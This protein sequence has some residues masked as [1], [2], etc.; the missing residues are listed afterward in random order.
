MRVNRR[1]VQLLLA[2]TMVLELAA[3]APAMAQPAEPYDPWEPFNRK[4]FAVNQV[5]DRHIFAPLAHAFGALPPVIRKPLTNFASNIGEPVVFLNDVL[6]GHVRP[7]GVTLGR[8]VMN[9]TVGIAGLM[10]PASHNHLPHHDNGLGTTFGRWGATPGP[11]LFLPFLGPSDLR[12]AVGGIGG[13]FM[14]PLYYAHF[15]GKPE[16]SA[17]TGVVNGLNAR[18][19]ADQAL[20]TINTTSTDPYATLRSFYL[21]N[22][23]ATIRGEAGGAGEAL[24]DFDLPEEPTADSPAPAAGAATKAP[25]APQAAPEGQA[26][27]EATAPATEPAPAQ[28]APDQAAPPEAAPAGVPPATSPRWLVQPDPGLPLRSAGGK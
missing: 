5:L 26:A 7:A 8:F 6:Q 23:A 2:S 10:D 4:M 17:V 16:V 3:A 28:S 20:N 18:L 19:E 9:S 21:Q 11:Y 13:V 12:D 1:R 22:R 15:N 27:P 24:P 25:G 14:S